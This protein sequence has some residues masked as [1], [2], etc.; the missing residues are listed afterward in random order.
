M[1]M[2]KLA[3]KYPEKVVVR[4]DYNPLGFDEKTQEL[5][6]ETSENIK[7]ADVVFTQNIHNYGGGYTVELCKRAQEEGK[8]LHYDNDDLLTDLN[9]DHR[10]YSVY[11]EQKLDEITKLI[12]QNADLVSVTQAKFAHRVQEY[13]GRA[14][15]VI[16]NAID[17]ELPCWN[18]PWT[19][20]PNK[21]H[22]RIGWAGGIHHEH[23]V[24]EV[25]HVMRGVNQKVGVPN[26]SWQF[27]GRPPKKNKTDKG[28]WQHDVWDNYEKILTMG[29][30]KAHRGNLAFPPAM[31]GDQYGAFFTQMDL[32]IAPLQMNAFND[33]KS[34]IKLIECG[35]YGLP[36]IA[37]NVGC[38]SEVIKNGE[39]GYLIPEHNPTKDWV[40]TL[41][42]VCKDPKHR[43]E[44]GMNLK[45]IVDENYDINKLIH[46]RLDLYNE[47]IVLKA[48]AMADFQAAMKKEKELETAND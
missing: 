7:W 23:D 41:T 4:F 42:K 26:V 21:K 16:K 11:K 25:P 17:F 37:S 46:Y 45:S 2:E 15:V 13:V 32:Q 22:T 36:L 44:M 3:E 34:E 48:K 47:L 9:E 6:D 5:P 27:Y 31:N 18:M 30:P 40:N 33:S 20:P 29:V 38:Y 8:F 14:L 28:D 1:P 12:Y 35:R 39:T 24:K 10:L 19:P 43:R